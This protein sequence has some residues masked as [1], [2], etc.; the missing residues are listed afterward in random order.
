LGVIFPGDRAILSI[1]AVLGARHKNK[2]FP[3]AYFFRKNPQH[4]QRE[5]K[6]IPSF[7][8]ALAKPKQFSRIQNSDPAKTSPN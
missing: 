6:T 5:I 1:A 2:A 3:M 8:I 4:H 7:L